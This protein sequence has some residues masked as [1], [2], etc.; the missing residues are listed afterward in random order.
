MPV[1]PTATLPVWQRVIGPF[2]HRHPAAVQEVAA[3]IGTDDGAADLGGLARALVLLAD[4][5][6]FGPRWRSWVRKP[7]MS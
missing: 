5:R 6:E 1:P 4:T 7:C 3:L 2:L